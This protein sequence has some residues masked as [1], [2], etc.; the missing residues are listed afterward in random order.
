MTT[1]SPWLSALRPGQLACLVS[2]VVVGA[3]LVD[4]SAA[5]RT[6][7]AAPIRFGGTWDLVDTCT[8]VTCKG[9]KYTQRF[10]IRQA[11]GS[12]HF[13]G[14]GVGGGYT[15]AV[16]GTQSGLSVHCTEI[17]YGERF[18]ITIKMSRSGKTFT[19]SYVDQIGAG[20]T[21]KATR[22]H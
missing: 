15:E 1:V 7:A 22:V 20:G 8:Y 14:T 3:L 11:P 12:S 19:G 18:K 17:G 10:T 6:S 9:T 2:A 13:A 5:A 4:S 16:K 21:I